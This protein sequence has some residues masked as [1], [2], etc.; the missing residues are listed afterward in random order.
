MKMKWMNGWMDWEI[1]IHGRKGKG[2]EICVTKTGFG[3]P[4]N[5]PTLCTTVSLLLPKLNSERP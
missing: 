1:K 5:I 3:K 2:G 4:Q